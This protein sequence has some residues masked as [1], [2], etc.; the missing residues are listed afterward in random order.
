MTKLDFSM[1]SDEQLLMA[2]Q[3]ANMKLGEALAHM[4]YNEHLDEL[5]TEVEEIRHEK[6]ARQKNG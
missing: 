4:I 3:N 2:E 1:M 6:E 5:Y